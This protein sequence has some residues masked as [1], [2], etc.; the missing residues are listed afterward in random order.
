M[1]FLALLAL[2]VS[3]LCL[4]TASALRSQEKADPPPPSY[5]PL[6]TGNQW[7]Y[8]LGDKDLDV[9]G[10]KG[11][12]ETRFAEGVGIVRMIVTIGALKTDIELDKFT[13]GK[14]P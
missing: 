5:Y 13:P 4:S 12:M 2:P 10:L 8:K 11:T 7:D 1:R 6:K 3:F 9:N 14:G